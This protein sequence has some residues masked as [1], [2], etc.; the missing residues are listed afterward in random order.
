[1]LN[2]AARRIRVGVR[3]HPDEGYRLIAEGPG[4][5]RPIGELLLRVMTAM[6]SGSW[7]RLK[8]CANPDCSR[9]FYDSS[10]NRSGRWCSMATCGNRMKARRFRQRGTGSE[11]R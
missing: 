7:R 2:E 11:D 4:I 3:I 9:A 6:G 5:D 8:L 1:V 10:R